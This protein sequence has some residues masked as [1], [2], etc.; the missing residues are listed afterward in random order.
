[1]SQETSSPAVA[2]TFGIIHLVY[3]GIFLLLSVY[4]VYSLYFASG[5]PQGDPV[6]QEM[7]SIQ[8]E[9][10]TIPSV[11]VYFLISQVVGFALLA[12][13]L[14]AGLQLLKRQPLGR[15]L[16][17]VF[18]WASIV[19]GILSTVLYMLLVQPTFKE[20]L[21]G[22]SLDENVL[23]GVQMMS[24]VQ[25]IMMFCCSALYPIII[26]IFLLPE[27]FARSLAP[28]TASDEAPPDHPTA[29]PPAPTQE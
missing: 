20:L 19:T 7:A 6:S 4:G 28:V 26:L 14:V 16:S 10:I 13:L 25:P 9:L 15:M 3:F 24:N 1:M 27:K 12:V 5:T 11:K 8:R 17:L 29:G 22:S 21:A 23:Q 18:A 2:K